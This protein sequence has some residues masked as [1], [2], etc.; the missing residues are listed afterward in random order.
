M[1]AKAADVTQDEAL[2]SWW[3]TFKRR[4]PTAIPT[5]ADSFAAGFDAARAIYMKHAEKAM[6]ELSRLKYPDTTGQ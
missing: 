6:D 3:E 4:N 2:Y 1:M 5:P